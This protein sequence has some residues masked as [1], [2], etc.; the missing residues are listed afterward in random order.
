MHVK[1][2]VINEER[3]GRGRILSLFPLAAALITLKTFVLAVVLVLVVLEQ[4]L[5]HACAGL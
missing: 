1:Y 3:T 2:S 5:V 4:S